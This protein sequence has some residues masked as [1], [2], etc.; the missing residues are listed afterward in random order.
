MC[1]IDFL[2][3]AFPLNGLIRS[4]CDRGNAN[5]FCAHPQSLRLIGAKMAGGRGVIA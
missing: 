3:N 1:S 2:V 4:V 5:V